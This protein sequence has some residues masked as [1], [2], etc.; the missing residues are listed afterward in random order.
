MNVNMTKI[1][2]YGV[3]ILCFLAI[4]ASIG[5]KK[6]YFINS[7]LH[8]AKF[9]GTAL[10]YLE[11]RPFLFDT[12][13]KVIKLAG[14]EEYFTDSTI[15]FF[16]PA[17]SSINRTYQYINQQLKLNGSDTLTSLEQI[18]PDFWR[19]TLMMYMFSGARGLEE[20]QQLDVNNRTAFPGE[21]VRSM[22]GRVMNVGVVFNDAS[23]LTYQ[24]YR[25][26]NLA[27]IPN[28]SSPQQGWRMSRIA[29]S[30]IRPKNGYVHV[31]VYTSHYF[32]FDPDQAYLN[33]NYLGFNR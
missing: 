28:Q 19:S 4:T 13:V 27:Y 12:L 3:S 26:L 30:N 23:G 24:G 32:G 5:C 6:E 17:D 10:Q 8:N 14:V 22:G 20:F 15:T 16:A 33:A 2:L 1:K 9:D 25:Q 21:Y 18:K 11:S 7:G 31:L 29:T